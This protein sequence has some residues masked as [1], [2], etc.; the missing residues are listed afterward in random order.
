MGVSSGGAQ[1]QQVGYGYAGSQLTSQTAAA[2]T[3]Q[4]Q[5]TFFAYTGTLDL[6]RSP[7]R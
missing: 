4:A 5:T 3:S 1:G 7:P 6:P 2:G